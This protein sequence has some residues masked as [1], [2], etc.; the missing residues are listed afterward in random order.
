MRRREAARRYQR[1]RNGRF[2]HAREAGDIG[3]REN[4]VGG[5]AVPLRSTP[6]QVWGFARL[7]MS[8]CADRRDRVG[9]IGAEPVL[10]GEH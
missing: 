8:R 2:N 3:R 7:G 6:I 10:G 4:L 1:S 5:I 9:A